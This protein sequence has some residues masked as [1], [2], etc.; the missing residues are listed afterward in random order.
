MK[1]YKYKGKIYCDEDLSESIKNYGGDLFGL[2]FDLK[3]DGKA[4]EQTLYFNPYDSEEYYETYE[5]LIEKEFD[6]LEVKEND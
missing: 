5:E 6:F 3:R 1:K 4:V 2:Y